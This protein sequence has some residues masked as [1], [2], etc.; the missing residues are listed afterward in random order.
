MRNSGDAARMT[1]AAWR[2]KAAQALATGL[3]N[4]LKPA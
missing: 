3:A 2:Q 4:F 1:S